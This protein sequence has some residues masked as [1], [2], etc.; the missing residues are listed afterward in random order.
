[1]VV[2]LMQAGALDLE[3]TEM[4]LRAGMH[5]LGSRVLE[6]LL[7]VDA[8]P[9][10]SESVDCGQGH[11]AVWLGWRAKQLLTVLGPIQIR[12]SYY[13]CEVCR[14]GVH[15]QDRQWDIEGTGNIQ[16]STSEGCPQPVM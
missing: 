13:Y 14:T 10:D 3:A 6:T 1:L 7:E 11:A 16:Q 9:L 2:R 12:R 15:W 5:Q 4:A 8:Q